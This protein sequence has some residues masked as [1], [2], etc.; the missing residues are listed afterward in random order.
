MRVLVQLKAS[1]PVLSAALAAAPAPT[2][3]ASLGVRLPHV[4]L[5][6]RYAPAQLPSSKIRGAGRG[7][8]AH[9]ALA[10]APEPVDSTY[11]VRGELPDD[12]YRSGAYDELCAHHSV[13]GVFADPRI[14][15]SLTCGGDPAV[16]SHA[17][18][19]TLLMVNQL[20]AL[21][22]TGKGVRLA[23]VDTGINR[24]HLVAQGRKPRVLV[25][26]S[27]TP[28]GVPTTPGRHPVDHGTMCAF[29]AGIAAPRARL[30]DHAVLLSRTPGSTVMSGLLSDALLAYSKL[31]GVLSGLNPAYRRM[32][33]SNSWGLFDPAWDFPVGHPGNYTDNPLHPFNLMVG[34]LEAAGADILFAAGNCGVQCPDGRCN[35]GGAPP[36]CGANSH[37]AVLSVAG[38]TV[39]KD[40]VGYS[41]QGPGRLT[42]LKPDVTGF[43]HFDGS[44]VYAPGPDSGTSA[45]CPVVAGVV[46]AVRSR[47]SAAALSPSQLRSL[48]RRTAED[49]GGGGYDYDYGFGLIDVGTLLPALP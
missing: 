4:R 46:A 23:I 21:G 1:A 45:A 20:A 16:G 41:S 2:T 17:D 11:L 42:K 19:A 43:T 9:A 33:V 13:Q 38:A 48:I 26:E 6:E 5:D 34:S 35:F 39:N 18:V 44:Q 22:M 37:P 29:D 3:G 31:R 47:Y 30:L 15:S 8:P 40:R 49:H 14:Q 24:A 36:I 12:A 27:Y 7:M 28:A 25:K 10:F 32:V